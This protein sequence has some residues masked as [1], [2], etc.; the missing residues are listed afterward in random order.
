MLTKEHATAKLSG[1][2]IHPDRLNKKDHGHYLEYAEKMLT[3]Y[4]EGIGKTRKELHHQVKELFKHE[5]E[6]PAKR[7]D[8]FCKLLDEVSD[9]DTDRSGKA[10]RL[11]KKVL[12]MAAGYHPLVEIKVG[13]FQNEE[14]EVK[15]KIAKKLNKKWADIE[16]EFFADV[17]EYH[18]LRRFNGYGGANEM[19]SRY[20]VAQVQAALYNAISMT[21]W[22][23]QDLKTILRYAKLARLLHTILYGD[24]GV[25][26]ILFDGP[27]SVLW[28]SRKY[29]ICMAKFL[30]TLLNC[31]DWR[32]EARIA[33][34]FNLTPR[35][36]LSPDHKL[37][38]PMPKTEDFDS[39]VEEEFALKWGEGTREGWTLVREGEI[40]HYGQKVFFPDFLLLHEGG[41]KVYLEI[42]GFWTP[43][44]LSSKV[45]TLEFFK[46]KNIIIAVAQAVSGKIPELP[47]PTIKYKSALKL[48][49]VLKVLESCLPESRK[50]L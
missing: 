43:E 47:F 37:K 7:I 16:Q 46:N 28:H 11:R 8:A 15:E 17:I 48:K 30:P 36:E 10:V 38:A 24:S 32:M 25:Y 45:E 41:Q 9:F 49:D 31:K 35:L 33:T 19:L 1:N 50:N 14:R 34:P 42:V 4:R 27:A 2:K 3:I 23:R 29:G 18:R 12:Q 20:N 22:T 40:L 21:V 5:P 6:C 13:L 26:E 39:L 44:Y